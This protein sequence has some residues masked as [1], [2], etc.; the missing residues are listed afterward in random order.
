MNFIGGYALAKERKVVCSWAGAGDRCALLGG[1]CFALRGDRKCSVGTLYESE[2]KR[3]AD[4]VSG[5]YDEI[6]SEEQITLLG[7]AIAR[8]MTPATA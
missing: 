2:N 4:N 1:V 3:V 7:K 5:K 6:Y 8:F